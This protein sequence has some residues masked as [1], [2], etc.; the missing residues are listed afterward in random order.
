MWRLRVR[1]GSV[2]E[3]SWGVTGHDLSMTEPS[4][5]HEQA[6]PVR[7]AKSA[8]QA[9][10]AQPV[11][12]AEQAEGW[13]PV[14]PTVGA[15]PVSSETGSDD[16]TIILGAEQQEPPPRPAPEDSPSAPS[17]GPQAAP[18][19]PGPIP[20]VGAPWPAGTSAEESYAARYGLVRPIAGRNLAGVCAAIGRSTGT[21]PVL[22]RVLL[23]VLSLAG[24]IG[25]LAYFVGWVLIPSEGDTAS[26]LEAMLGRGQSGTSP[27]IVLVV[28]AIVVLTVAYGIADGHRSALIGTATIVG[29]A[30]L[31]TRRGRS[32]LAQPGF[33]TGAVP[34]GGV[35][36]PAGGTTATG[37]PLSS[38]MP[39]PVAF[40]APSGS[41]APPLTPHGPFAGR[42]PY[43]AS[44]GY[45]Y[46]KDQPLYP[47][48][49]P[50]YPG[51]GLPVPPPVPRPPRERSALGR[52]TISVLLLALGVVAA[53]DLSGADLSAPVY[54]ATALGVIALG[55]LVGG[56]Y[57]RAR[58]LVPIGLLL[59]AALGIST[60]AVHW[61]PPHQTNETWAPISADLI[62]RNYAIDM[63][64]AT[65]D[66][67]R[68]D[69]T[70]KD[71][72]V[73]VRG[74]MG[75]LT[76]ILP[77]AVD[78]D[79]RALVKLGDAQV[80]AEQWGGINSTRHSVRDLGKDGEGG[81]HVTINATVDMG[82][83][84]V[85]R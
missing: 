60:V 46:P 26:P 55:L 75:S 82:N 66:L 35:A 1:S 48:P 45:D 61:D 17:T 63:G 11:E 16:A 57:G 85:H 69:F 23:A 67:S 47:P 68:V 62:E 58:W 5:A 21:D 59:S 52:I 81:G 14:E 71:V 56:W 84:E 83:L 39:T 33:S 40:A 64:D 38:P 80:F 73:D 51:L 22:W 70:G 42:S 79:V 3:V 50:P 15:P 54:I 9:E 10:A 24:G 37:D 6:E 41:A 77:P 13:Q 28:G 29:I 78:V 74:K 8:E 18:G 53:V 36:P 31:L 20:G 65:L 4:A 43:A 32:P 34:M 30:Y 49:P 25:L 27:V 12:P 19:G 72:E 2:P 7:L 76:V 44:L